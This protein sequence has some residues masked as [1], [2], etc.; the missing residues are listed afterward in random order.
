MN[1]AT[2]FHI[3]C[4]MPYKNIDKYKNCWIGFE[5]Y[6]ETGF[7]AENLKEFKLTNFVQFDTKISFKHR[8][9]NEFHLKIS[10]KHKRKA[11]GHK[12]ISFSPFNDIKFIRDFLIIDK[13]EIFFLFAHN[14]KFIYNKP[15][16]MNIKIEENEH[17]PIFIFK[18]ELNCIWDTKISYVAKFTRGFKTY[19]VKA[20]NVHDRLDFQYLVRE[21]TLFLMIDHPC[22]IEMLSH[23]C[24]ERMF[25]FVLEYEENGSLLKCE[26]NLVVMKCMIDICSVMSYLHTK[27]IVHRD[28]KP[29]NILID[30]NLNIKLTDFGTTRSFV[31]DMT[32]FVGTAEFMAPEVEG[33]HY[34]FSADVYSAGAVA[35][36]LFDRKNFGKNIMSIKKGN[37]VNSLPYETQVV[38]RAMLDD[39][40]SKRPTFREIFILYY[41]KSF[42]TIND[43]NEFFEARA[44]SFYETGGDYIHYK[45]SRENTG[46]FHCLMFHI[47]HKRV[48]K[49]GDMSHLGQLL[50]DKYMSYLFD[51]TVLYTGLIALDIGLKKKTDMFE[52]YMDFRADDYRFYLLP[53]P[54]MKTTKYEFDETLLDDYDKGLKLRKTDPILALEYFMKAYKSGNLDSKYQIGRIYALSSDE[55]CFKCLNEFALSGHKKSS[56]YLATFFVSSKYR[57]RHAL[58]N[59]FLSISVKEWLKYDQYEENERKW[60]SFKQFK[61]NPM[62]LK[63]YLPLCSYKQNLGTDVFK[64]YRIFPNFNVLVG[65]FYANVLNDK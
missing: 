7:L 65:I 43:P 42:F 8:I 10:L 50:G 45:K 59:Y 47:L 36:F 58:V 12:I 5:I 18:E 3:I 62:Y 46:L 40:P 44:Y 35:C 55:R 53:A 37:H 4:G 25:G 57:Q 54:R 41:Q 34:D 61:D 17:A 30:S 13:L 23:S 39:D 1:E 63:F 38:L 56:Y 26:K 29:G 60:R 14:C 19:V 11:F 51:W 9:I 48:D 31:D 20:V 33:K 49:I 2:T 15:L 6:T 28:L 32:K 16:Y 24:I 64:I 21:L 22:M 27:G 52:R